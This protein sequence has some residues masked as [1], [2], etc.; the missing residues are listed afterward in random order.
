MRFAPGL[1]VT[2]KPQ[3]TWGAES[4]ANRDAEAP[5]GAEYH[6]TRPIPIP[7]LAIL[8]QAPKTR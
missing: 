1:G 7:L 4:G 2:A 8:R 6:R 5:H 3:A